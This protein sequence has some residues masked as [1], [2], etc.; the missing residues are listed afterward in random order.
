MEINNIPSSSI[1]DILDI[2]PGDV[3]MVSAD[4]SKL[5]FYAKK[6]EGVFD[7]Q[8]FIESLSKKINP[9]GTLVIP[10]YTHLLE[11]G[12]KFDLNSTR[13]LTGTLAIEALKNPDF[14]RT[15]HPLHSFAVSG[16]YR[17]EMCNL[18]NKSS[19]G[20]DSP[21]SF[22]HQ[23]NAKLLL[24][25]LDLHNSL[26]F[27]H[28]V[29]E[30]E[31]VRYR[32]MKKMHFLYTDI[33]G[34]TA[35]RNYLLYKKFPWITMDFNPL[36]KV[37]NPAVI[38]QQI[39]NGINFRI[40]QLTEVYEI[41]KADIHKNHAKRIA[42]YNWSIFLKFIVK[43]ILKKLNLYSSSSDKIRNADIL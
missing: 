30:N 41:I 17:E 9:G 20:P 34:I 1:A 16:K 19:F 32:Y 22:L 14:K 26:T 27:T 12:D 37:I 42:K 35:K 40:L 11:S 5:A 15:A 4:V 39:I 2:H 24:V 43:S 31:K 21:F 28:Y 29:E 18:T 25:D 8:K 7:P 36:E 38:Q 10:T 6:K 33:S 3:V 13:P 23:K